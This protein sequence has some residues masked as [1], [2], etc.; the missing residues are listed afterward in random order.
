MYNLS[1]PISTLV[2][3]IGKPMFAECNLSGTQK[4]VFVEFTLKNYQQNNTLRK[5]VFAEC[6]LRGLLRYT[7][8]IVDRP[9]K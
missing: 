7:E 1:K 2:D 3:A 5:I 6:F 4:Q 9:F 8:M